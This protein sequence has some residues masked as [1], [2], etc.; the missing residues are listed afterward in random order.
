MWFP[1]G[2]RL[3]AM[4]SRGTTGTI[5]SY[6]SL[7]TQTILWF[8]DLEPVLKFTLTWSL[9]LFARFSRANAKAN[10][11]V[12]IY[13][14]FHL[15]EEHS[16]FSALC[17]ISETSELFPL[18]SPIWLK[19][20]RSLFS[21]STLWGTCVS[22]APLEVSWPEVYGDSRLGEKNVV[23]VPLTDTSEVGSFLQKTRS[24][25]KFSVQLK[26]SDVQYRRN[27]QHP[28]CWYGYGHGMS[29]WS[30][31]PSVEVLAVGDVC[32]RLIPSTTWWEQ[33]R[34]CS[35]QCSLFSWHQPQPSGACYT[36]PICW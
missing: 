34:W 21:S 24:F 11:V 9:L 25:L 12:H 30:Q 36:D 1:W 10:A 2:K 3:W 6:R 4:W 14:L 32:P 18:G 20:E 22:Y 8:Y 26:K 28:C 19:F 29:E 35:W 33:W 16:C 15:R 7:P 5:W 23:W 31:H 27:M 17:L 13:I